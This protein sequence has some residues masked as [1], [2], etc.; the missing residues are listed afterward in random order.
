MGDERTRGNEEGVPD[1]RPGSCASTSALYCD[2]AEQSSPAGRRSDAG[3]RFPSHSGR[4]NR[5]K[6]DQGRRNAA[7]GPPSVEVSARRRKDQRIRGHRLAAARTRPR[8]RFATEALIVSIWISQRDGPGR[9][10]GLRLLEPGSSSSLP[11]PNDWARCRGHR[12][13]P[14]NARTN[15]QAPS[16]RPI[17]RCAE[18][19]TECLGSGHLPGIHPRSAAEMETAGCRQLLRRGKQ[20]VIQEEGPA[21]TSEHRLPRMKGTDHAAERHEERPRRPPWRIAIDVRLQTGD[22]P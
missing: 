19:M 16:R 9:E 8:R 4:E 20:A 10:A 12:R 17:H 22:E 7:G 2:P 11:S 18:G 1:S 15:L 5:V 13:G 6:Q 3:P 14:G 21:R